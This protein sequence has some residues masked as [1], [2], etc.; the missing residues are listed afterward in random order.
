MADSVQSASPP[1]DRPRIAEIDA[2]RGLAAVAVMLYHYTWWYDHGMSGHRETPWIVFPY[3][4][5]GVHLFFMISGFVIIMTVERRRSVAEFA[6]ARFSRL[7]PVYWAAVALCF[8]L[9]CWS[10][11]LP[12][13]TASMWDGLWNLSMVQEAVGVPDVNGSFWTLYVELTFYGVVA[14]LMA[15]RQLPRLHWWLAGLVC[16]DAVL[17]AADAWDW[18]P[19]LWRVSALFPLHKFLYLFLFGVWIYRSRTKLS[20][21][22]VPVCML[23]LIDAALHG[24]WQ[25]PIVVGLAA[26]FACAAWGALPW[27]DRGTLR[28]LGGISYSLYLIHGPVGYSLIR[29]GERFDW[30]VNASIA[31]AVAVSVVIGTALTYAIERPT[32]EWLRTLRR[33]RRERLSQSAAVAVGEVAAQ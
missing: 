3:G 22:L 25:L 16:L 27:L 5:F 15:F 12:E 2:L 18:V 28:F 33:R 29:V 9:N 24:I 19:G 13:R 8:G 14:F 11:L 30:N 1:N 21:G 4:A 23:C 6:Y 32:H 10:G 26:L 20:S 31:A 7:Y 17:T